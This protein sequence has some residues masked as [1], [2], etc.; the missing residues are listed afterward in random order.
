[1]A[2]FG[3]QLANATVTL[4]KLASD[5]TTLI[6]GMLP[7]AGGQMAGNLDLNG[8]RIQNLPAPLNGA[9]PARLQDIQAMPWKEKCA[10]ATSGN[11]DLTTGGTAQSTALTDGRTPVIGQRA[12]VHKQSNAAQNGIYI[13]NAGTWTRAFDADTT[14]DL[15]AAMVTV[16]TGTLY[17]DHRFAQ[18]AELVT[19]GSDNVTW[20]DIG[21]GA[22]AGF[23][24]TANKGMEA[25]ATSGS[26]ALACMTQIAATPI[27]GSYVQVL[28]NG[29]ALKLGDGTRDTVDC[30]FSSTA[31]AG[32]AA[33]SYANIAAGDW[34]YWTGSAAGG[35]GYQ[36]DEQ[37][38]LDFNYLV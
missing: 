15:R 9:E 25:V 31:S 7:K 8:F 4:A 35:P 17:G 29:V 20:V 38:R 14:D 5:V 34:L 2:I 32:A 3:K 36:L 12:L 1:M 23:P 22:P 33:R 16:E 11:F 30:Y 37:D 21:T 10:F 24:T 28:L 26:Y 27:Q 19:L 6:N 13:V 18:T